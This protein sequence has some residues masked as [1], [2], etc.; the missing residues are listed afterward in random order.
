MLTLSLLRTEQQQ[1]RD[2]N[3]KGNYIS[4]YI[5]MLVRR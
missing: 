3:I 2:T 4:F 1:K 5:T